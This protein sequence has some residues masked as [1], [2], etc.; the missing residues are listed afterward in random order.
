MDGLKGRFSSLSQAALSAFA[1]RPSELQESVSLPAPFRFAQDM[2]NAEQRTFLKLLNDGLQDPAAKEAFQ[3]VAH[4]ARQVVLGF[5]RNNKTS[6]YGAQAV[7]PVVQDD[8]YYG[9]FI[10][11]GGERAYLV[12]SIARELVN[13]KMDV[14]FLQKR[15][16]LQQVNQNEIKI[17]DMTLHV[18]VLRHV[19]ASDSRLR[20]IRLL[21]AEGVGLEIPEGRGLYQITLHRLN[22]SNMQKGIPCLRWMVKDEKDSEARLMTRA[23]FDKVADKL[24]EAM[25]ILDKSGAVPLTQ[26]MQEKGNRKGLAAMKSDVLLKAGLTFL[27]DETRQFAPLLCSVPV[28]QGT[29]ASLKV[30]PRLIPADERLERPEQTV[31]YTLEVNG[32]PMRGDGTHGFEVLRAKG[33]W[34]DM[35]KDELAF[36]HHTLSRLIPAEEKKQAPAFWAALETK[37]MGKAA[38]HVRLSSERFI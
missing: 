16:N 36:F 14:S 23:D 24:T 29:P 37:L 11:A 1:G 20:G 21:T 28:I 17:A 15:S 7:T 3:F 12:Q 6:F 31:G 26:Y 8:G 4:R 25:R 30:S 18:P 32:I 10:Q 35:N 33:V 5:S 34:A 27:F 22:Q 2:S 9:F 19:L 38:P 13:F